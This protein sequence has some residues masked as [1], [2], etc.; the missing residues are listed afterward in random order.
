MKRFKLLA[1]AFAAV[2]VIGAVGC[3]SSRELADEDYPVAG[4]YSDV[5]FGL[6]YYPSYWGYSGYGYYPRTYIR[7]RPR[8]E[9]RD[10]NHGRTWNQ[11]QGRTWSQNRPEARQ[12]VLGNSRRH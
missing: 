10:W 6:G 1:I 4:P 2:L 9:G 7:T 11:S 8:Y 12:R 3:T 5:I